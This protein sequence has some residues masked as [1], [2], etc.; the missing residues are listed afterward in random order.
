MKWDRWF[1]LLAFLLLGLYF[2]EILMPSG[3]G[4]SWTPC[5]RYIGFLDAF[6]GISFRWDNRVLGLVC[7]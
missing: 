6:F 7:T 5:V 2:L 3:C 4:A 1:L